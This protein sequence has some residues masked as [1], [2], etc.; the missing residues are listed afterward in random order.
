MSRRASLLGRIDRIVESETYVGGHVESLESGVFRSD[1]PT[2]FQLDPAALQK[3]ADN[4]DRD[5]RGAALAGTLASPRRSRVAKSAR[6][7][8]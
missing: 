7:L 6:D 8:R 3:L 1:I 4:V 5:R 2:S